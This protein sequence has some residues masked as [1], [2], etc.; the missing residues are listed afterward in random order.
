MHKAIEA[1]DAKGVAKILSGLGIDMSGGRVPT[2]ESWNNSSG[3]SSIGH[4]IHPPE[5]LKCLHYTYAVLWDV[6][7][8]RGFDW[9][10]VEGCDKYVDR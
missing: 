1:N 2:I 10:V 7:L 3:N 6:D 8:I 4:P 9:Y 5:Y